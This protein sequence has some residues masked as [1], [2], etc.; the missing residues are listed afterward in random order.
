MQSNLVH[1]IYTNQHPLMESGKVP[2]ENTSIFQSGVN[3]LVSVSPGPI[4]LP[5]ELATKMLAFRNF[6]DVRE[7][8]K[9]I[10]GQG[11][12]E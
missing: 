5:N 4:L 12:N 6:S 2:C 1:K 9:E 3:S 8:R 11:G 7:A 10:L